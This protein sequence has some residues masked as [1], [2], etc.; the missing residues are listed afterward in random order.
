MFVALFLSTFVPDSLSD[1]VIL[2]I[3]IFIVTSIL[4]CDKLGRFVFFR[5]ALMFFSHYFINSI[6]QQLLFPTSVIQLTICGCL[7]SGRRRLNIWKVSNISGAMTY[8][9]GYL[10]AG[11]DGY[12]LVYSQMYYT[13]K[14]SFI[15]HD[16]FINERRVLK[17]VY[18]VPSPNR[19][20]QTQ[21]LGGVFR[22]KEGQTKSIGTASITGNFYFGNTTSYFGAFMIHH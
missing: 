10:T 6:F 11:V 20:Y 7:F 21:Y 4:C 19:K 3:L 16:I 1:D 13:D 9:D 14:N 22:V 8:R 17:A 5:V 2:I 15:G 12:Y 18:S